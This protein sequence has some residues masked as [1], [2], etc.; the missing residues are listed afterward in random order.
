MFEKTEFVMVVFYQS[1]NTLNAENIAQKFFWRSWK[2]AQ[3]L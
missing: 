2:V 3:Y 1:S